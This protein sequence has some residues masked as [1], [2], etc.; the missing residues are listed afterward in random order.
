MGI[1]KT[2]TEGGQI[3][4]HRVR[5]AKQVLKIASSVSL[6]LALIF[7]AVKFMQIPAHHYQ[8]SFHY[9]HAKYL[10]SPSNNL[11]ISGKLWGQITRQST[12]Q[13]SLTFRAETITKACERYASLTRIRLSHIFDQ[14][15]TFSS[16]TFTTSLLFFLIRGWRARRKQHVEGK[17]VISP[18][19]LALKLTLSFRD[20]PLKIGSI[21][22]VKD[23]ET[24][25]TLVSGATG[26]GK[27]N[28]YHALL[29]QIRKL[30]QRALIVDITGEFVEKYY[31]HG[32]DVLL[33]PFDSRSASWHPWCECSDDTD[34]KSLAQSF[35][36]SSYRED[37][38]FWRDGAQEIFYAALKETSF[39]CRTSAL[40]K[41]LL[42]D[43][44]ASL[45]TYLKGTTAASYLD[46]SSEKTAGSFRAVAATF[47]KSLEFVPDT[48]SP[49]S[50]RQWVTDE[51]P[52]SWLF[53]C[54]T[55]KHRASITSLLSAWLSIGISSLLQLK[56]NYDRRLWFVIDELP[57]L[58]R[59]KYLE[60]FL[61]ES[62]KFGGCGLLAIQSP[63]Q[64]ETIYGKEITS[65]LLGNCATR[66]AFAEYDALTAERISR[67]FGNKEVRESHEALS[68]G[69]HEMRDGVNLSYQTKTSSVISPTLLQS[70]GTLEAF[71]K[72]PGNLPVSKVKLPFQRVP[73]ITESFLPNSN[74]RL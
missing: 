35:I 14:T 5:M 30:G 44:L 23:T 34:I 51:K 63:A 66:I 36:P 70:L 64:L 55:P 29:P 20:S 32:Q 52:G 26:T 69:A 6:I 19:K 54:C 4:A 11:T 73:K 22:F 31:R 9:I 40:S 50:I 8:A 72:L 17:R 53:L 45:S 12:S 25:H 41:L 48:Q 27:T 46:L 24:H 65:T 62:R 15:L 7:F 33:N 37:D 21:P 3:W 58:N 13:K 16:Y 39:R 43:S 56:P 28:T 2:I 57:K 49:F 60:S 59:L 10:S 74:I 71:V 68:Y 1:L 42:H 47:L 38:N 67:S 18:R 61:T